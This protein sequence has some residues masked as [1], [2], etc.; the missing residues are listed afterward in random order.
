M[1]RRAVL[2]SLLCVAACAKKMGPRD[3]AAPEAAA[4]AAPGG[5]FGLQDGYVGETEGA[6]R[7]YVAQEPTFDE[8]AARFD[9][10]D[11]D[12]SAQGISGTE[13]TPMSTS[14]AP[15]TSGKTV[16]TKKDQMS[17][18]ER[19]CGLKDAICDVS[20][21]ICGLAETHQDEDK[22][23]EA[24]TRSQGRCEQAADACSGCR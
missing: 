6:G 4:T 5:D 10:L 20:D 14:V 13:E 12:L 15:E 24:C 16:D 22:Y 18:C 2:L 1:R 23:T 19:I 11:A 9:R 8:L 7:D 17:R 21:R 3:A